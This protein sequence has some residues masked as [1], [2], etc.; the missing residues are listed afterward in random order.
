MLACSIRICMHAWIALEAN[1]YRMKTDKHDN[2]RWARALYH[3]DDCLPMKKIFGG[4]IIQFSEKPNKGADCLKENKHKLYYYFDGWFLHPTETAKHSR[5]IFKWI[6]MVQVLGMYA[7]IH[8]VYTTVF[9]LCRLLG[10]P[11]NSMLTFYEN[12]FDW[13]KTNYAWNQAMQCCDHSVDAHQKSVA[14]RK[15]MLMYMCDL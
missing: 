1:R 13:V 4:E 5:R 6:C 9:W 14:N 12:H 10:L 3:T 11:L 7:C 2:W 15:T 8:T